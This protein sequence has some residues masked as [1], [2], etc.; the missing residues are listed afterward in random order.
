MKDIVAVEVAKIDTKFKGITKDLQVNI[1]NNG[2]T[3]DEERVNED[4]QQADKDRASAIRSS[5][6]V[7][8]QRYYQ[9][10][11]EVA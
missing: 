1:D 11:V 10:K 5:K 3:L 8:W 2:I 7:I 9:F 4:E 6:R